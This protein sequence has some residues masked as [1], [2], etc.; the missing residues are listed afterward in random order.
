MKTL[1]DFEQAVHAALDNQ[2]E[3]TLEKYAEHACDNFDAGHL[4]DLAL[5]MIKGD[6]AGKHLALIKIESRIDRQRAEFIE[7]EAM[8]RVRLVEA[9]EDAA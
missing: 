9:M 7:M 6:S 2:D 1:R 4:Q 8:R 5:A 3:Y